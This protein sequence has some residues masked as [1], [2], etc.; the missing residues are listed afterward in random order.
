M[1]VGKNIGRRHHI[2]SA[3]DTLGNVVSI[4]SFSDSVLNF[5]TGFS[6]RFP[7]E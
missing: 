1:E 4:G 3:S 2:S 5:G 6:R 7:Y